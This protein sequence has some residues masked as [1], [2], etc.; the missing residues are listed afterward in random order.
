MQSELPK[1]MAAMNTA[2]STNTN[3][4]HNINTNTNTKRKMPPLKRTLVILDDGTQCIQAS[5]RQRL[6]AHAYNGAITLA[7]QILLVFLPGLFGSFF[8]PVEN[9]QHFLD[10][11][12]SLCS[13]GIVFY[14]GLLEQTLTT[15][16]S[17]NGQNLGMSW[18]GIKL[19]RY[20][21]KP[22]DFR[23]MCLWWCGHFIFPANILLAS[24][25]P[26]FGLDNT[27]SGTVVVEST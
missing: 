23:T 12:N 27:L 20:D 4:T 8:F 9:V 10:S 6:V 25:S 21:G 19:V 1:R 16:I 7:I 17:D 13:L 22:I 15:L 2:T 14:N 26:R 5:W 24:I 3:I 11:T 18:A